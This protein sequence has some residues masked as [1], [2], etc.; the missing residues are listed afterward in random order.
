MEALL[1][2]G[3]CGLVFAIWWDRNRDAYRAWRERAR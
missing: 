1:I 3:F 2:I